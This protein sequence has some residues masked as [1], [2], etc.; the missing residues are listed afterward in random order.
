[1]PTAGTASM[2]EPAASPA[3]T[4]HRSGRGARN[5]TQTPTTSS[6][7][8]PIRGCIARVPSSSP[9]ATTARPASNR[10]RPSNT[11][12]FASSRG[13]VNDSFAEKI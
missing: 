12:A 3:S 8:R 5:K 1:M 11:N 2:T 7:T 4:H 13:V 9:K 6:P 10:S